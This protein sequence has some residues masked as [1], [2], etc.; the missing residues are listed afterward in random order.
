ME[1]SAISMRL[2]IT[3]EFTST[4]ASITKNDTA[5][6]ATADAIAILVHSDSG[7][8]NPSRSHFDRRIGRAHLPGSN[9]LGEP[10]HA[11]LKYD[12]FAIAGPA[13]PLQVFRKYGLGEGE[14]H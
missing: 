11:F 4:A 7:I 1:A 3:L 8:G 2:T 6:T 9:P 14:T 12:R 5:M 10:T 13:D